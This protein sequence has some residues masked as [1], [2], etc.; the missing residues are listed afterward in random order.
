[1]PFFRFTDVGEAGTEIFIPVNRLYAEAGIDQYG[2]PVVRVAALGA[3]GTL[4]RRLGDME[5]D[6]PR[7][8]Q[9]AETKEELEAMIEWVD[10]IIT[11]TTVMDV[12]RRELDAQ[13]CEA[14]NIKAARA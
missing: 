2:K 8:V 12:V 13:R 6:E 9:V 7:M 10:T 1:M 11:S 3:H 5:V 4:H 14:E